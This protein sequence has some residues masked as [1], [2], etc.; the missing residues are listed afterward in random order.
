M[1]G[2]EIF[3]GKSLKAEDLNGVEPIVTI[4]SVSVKKFDDGTRKPVVSF[5]GKEKTLVCNKTNWNA[6]VEITGEEDSDNWTGHR[7]KLIVAKVDFQGKRVPAIRV[8][9]P[10]RT[11]TPSPA[12]RQPP[13][14]PEPAPQI[15]DDDIPF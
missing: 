14:P 12:F 13:P 4:D 2:N 10:P 3:S 11:N 7:I 8:E 9:A 6:I 15:N 1:K 5:K